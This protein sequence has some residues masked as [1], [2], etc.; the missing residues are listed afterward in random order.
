MKKNYILLVLIFSVTLASCEKFLEFEPYGQPSSLGTL[1]DGQAMQTVYALYEWQYNEGTTGRGFFWYE[2]ASD[3]MVTGRSQAQ[4]QNI[5]NFVDNGSSSRDV[6][7]NWPKMYQTINYANQ[8]IKQVPG[9]ESISENVRDLVVGNAYYWRG[10]AYLWIAPWYGDNGPNGGIPIVTE[11]T[12]VEEI[13]VPRPAS[14]LENYELIISDLEK[15]GELLPWF[16]EL[17]ADQWGL[18]HKTAAWSMA[19][20]AALYAAQYDPSYYDKVIMY[21]DRVINSGK[22]ALQSTYAD[23]FEIENNWGPEYI[24][25]VTSNENDGAKW[26]GISFQNGGF[27]YYN[28]WGYFQPTKELYDAFEPGDERLKKTIIAPGDTVDFVGNQIIWQVNPS[29]TSSPTGM[30]LGKWLAPFRGADAIGTRV[31]PNGNN[32]TTRL[33]VHLIRY[34]DVLLMKAEALIWKNGEGDPVAKELLNDIRERA[35]LARNSQATKAQLKNERRVELA[36]EFG[37]WRHL[38]LVRWG[39][40]KDTYSQPLH[41]FKVNLAGSSIESLE[42]IEVWPARNFDPTIHHVFPI[43]T[44]EIATSKNLT[45][46]QGY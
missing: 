12:P 43:P 36:F 7:D 30:T 44:R 28:T 14:I 3:D 23:V 19:A 20:R 31:N 42:T 29:S 24:Y 33:N 25:S 21:A 38:D 1:T 46:N 22:H 40:A 26:P 18:T 10:F 39:D 15:A 13:D 34:A 9:S 6:R 35:G 45:Q 5:K 4:A 32:M 37:S 27:G 17:P 41:G 16:D 11:E 2:N 8:I